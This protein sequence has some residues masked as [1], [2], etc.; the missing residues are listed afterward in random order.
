MHP[1][2]SV[3]HQSE[4]LGMNRTSVYHRPKRRLESLE[5]I[6]LMRRIDVLYTELPYFGNGYIV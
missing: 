2:L 3:K 6:E 5:N 1:K 4:L